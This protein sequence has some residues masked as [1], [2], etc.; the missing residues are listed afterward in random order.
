[1]RLV[2]GET[3]EQIGDIFTGLSTNDFEEMTITDAPTG[4]FFA[5]GFGRATNNG[6]PDAGLVLIGKIE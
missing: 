4:D 2:S 1:M 3:G 5:V 6:F